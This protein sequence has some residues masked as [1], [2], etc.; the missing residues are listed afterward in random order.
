MR[1]VLVILGTL[2]VLVV[3]F[4]LIALMGA[5]KPKP[6]RKESEPRLPAA[7]V[8]NVSYQPVALTVNAQ[9]EVRPRREI[10]VVPQVGGRIVEVSPNFIDGGTIQKGEVLVQLEDADYRSSLTRAEARVAQAQQALQV[11]EAETALAQQDYRELGGDIDDASALALRE[12]QLALAK[13]EFEA[14]KADLADARLAV[15]RTQIVA[16]FTGRVRSIAADVGQYVGPGTS[17]GQIFSTDVAEVRLPLTD[18]DLARLNLPF[19]F[20]ASYGE[21]PAVTFTARAA[22]A[23]R[24]WTGY[25]VRTD[26]AIDPT[27][28]QIAAI[29][30]VRDPYG[31]GADRSKA[32]EGGR[33]FPMAIGLFVDA[34]IAGPELD[35][36]VVLPRLAVQEGGIVHTLAEDD[37]I[38]RTEVVVAATTPEG[39]VVTD[40]LEEGERVIISRLPTA[41]GKKIR[42]LRPGE[43]AAPER[44]PDEGGVADAGAAGR[45]SGGRAGAGAGR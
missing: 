44:A 18:A 38:E 25:V 16:P 14:A 32:V 24:E 15:Q 12:P 30:Q 11:E 7:F 4:G 33:G 13:A 45:T 35:R 8:Q 31:A 42:P 28:R 36:A 43:D 39:F 23:E 5:L 29:A 10:A 19:A 26:A 3:G 37:T 34:A 27:T 21:G 2:G 9:G 40:G 20:D 6:E 17:I 1:K 22:G 41:V